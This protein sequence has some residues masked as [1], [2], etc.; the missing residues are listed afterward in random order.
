MHLNGGKLVKCHLMGI[1]C[2]MGKW[3]EDQLCVVCSKL[4]HGYAQGHGFKYIVD[5]R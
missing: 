5:L 3:I 2:R 1:H 4:T